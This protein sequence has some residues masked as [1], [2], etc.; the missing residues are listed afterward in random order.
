MQT[1]R[2]TSAPSSIVQ[3]GCI[4]P[5]ATALRRVVLRSVGSALFSLLTSYLTTHEPPNGPARPKPKDMKVNYARFA[6][7]ADVSHNR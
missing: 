5:K 2:S 4:L 6:S 7:E 1:L 3:Q